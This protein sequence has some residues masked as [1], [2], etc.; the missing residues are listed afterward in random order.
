MIPFFDKVA[1]THRTSVSI[2]RI[3]RPPTT[4]APKAALS[5]IV[6]TIARGVSVR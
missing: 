3:K 2:G 6:S 1:P 4:M 5:A